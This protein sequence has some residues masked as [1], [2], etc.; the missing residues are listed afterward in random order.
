MDINPIHLCYSHRE[1]DSKIEY[2]EEP[3]EGN[4]LMLNL[5][6]EEYPNQL[7]NSKLNKIP[8]ELKQTAFHDNICILIFIAI[9]IVFFFITYQNYVALEDHQKICNFVIV[10]LNNFIK[11]L[12]LSHFILLCT[13]LILVSII[14]G[15]VQVFTMIY[16]CKIFIF[17]T[18]SFTLIINLSLVIYLYIEKQWIYFLISTILMILLLF[19]SKQIYKRF[20]FSIAFINLGSKILR[21]NPILWLV[22]LAVLLINLTTTGI[23]VSVFYLVIDNTFGIKNN[24]KERYTICLLLV[25]VG[26]YINDIIQ[27]STK[28]IVGAISAKWYFNSKI[29]NSKAIFHTFVKGFGSICLGSLL[30]SITRF[31]KEL[32][33]ILEPNDNIKKLIILNSLWK[34]TEYFLYLV[35]FTLRY[36]NEY[37]FAYISIYNE[38]YFNSSIKMFKIFQYKGYDTLIND[39]IVKIILRLY[40]ICLGIIGGITSF[41]CMRVLENSEFSLINFSDSKIKWFTILISSFISIQIASVLSS[42]INSYIH[43]I[44]ICLIEH[45]D[46]LDLEHSN[47]K[48]FRKIV[49]YLAPRPVNRVSNN[50]AIIYNR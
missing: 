2:H 22:Y 48:D 23:Y 1:L 6:Q 29:S 31:L 5:M 49:P 19:I 13:C 10:E 37:S 33:S 39:S 28:I 16:F 27:N 46:I 35:D 4:N 9:L 14:L 45:R 34:L 20:T 24:A 7:P 18:I 30:S 15:L 12:T 43:V 47:D 36:F 42:I 3:K 40:M 41:I 11:K 38:D 44:L 21:K 25:F 32:I 26:I 8:W 17:G 50:E